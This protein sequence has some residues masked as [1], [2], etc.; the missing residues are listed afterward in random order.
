MCGIFG[1]VADK[2]EYNTI[3]QGL[4]NLAYRGYDSA[5]IAVATS[6]G[7][8]IERTEGHPKFLPDLGLTGTVAIGHN[9][10]ATHSPPTKE[11][12]H[13]YTSNDNKISL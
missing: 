13:P 1:S 5:G 4:K 2:V 6:Q 9:R 12:S 7:V 11:N 10:W 8:I 3:K